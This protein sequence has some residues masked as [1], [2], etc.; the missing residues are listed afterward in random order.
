V[1]DR[2]PLRWDDVRVFLAARRERT[3]AGAARA[4]GVDQTTVGRRLAAIEEALDARL[5]DRTPEGLV[6][7]PAGEAI[8]D[9]AERVEESA[10]ALVRR[11]FGE[12]RRAEGTVRI[13]TSDAFA[14]HFLAP[15]LGR[16]R[17]R[18][19][20][21]VL[22]LCTG[23]S[24]VAL[25]RREADVAV[26]L[27]PK[28]SPPAQENVICRRLADVAWALQAS[29]AYVQRHGSPGDAE[30]LVGHDVVGLDDDAP[31]LPGGDWLRKA[32][33]RAQV[34]ARVTSIVTALA[35]AR[36]GLGLAL[37]PCFMAEGGA[38]ARVGPVRAWAEAWMLVHP[39]LQQVARVRAVM[40]ALVQIATE[41]AALL[42]GDVGPAL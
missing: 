42:R 35:A 21:I 23:Q 24:F 31:S 2:D 18:H 36:A 19:P 16:V 33:A 30:D 6:L 27:R 20:G 34:V 5:F 1:K 14:E 7:T 10:H 4:L 13:A 39:D 38:L 15:R 32:S 12:D 17:A 28:G 26:R 29:P 41:E 40:D 11:A 9:A 22:E 8:V 3:M 37:L 25:S